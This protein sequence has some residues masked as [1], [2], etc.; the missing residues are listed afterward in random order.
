VRGLPGAPPEL[1][2]GRRR[3]TL[4][5]VQGCFRRTLPLDDVVTGQEFGRVE[6]LPPGWLVEG[7]LLKVRRRPGDGIITGRILFVQ[8]GS[9]SS[10]ARWR[11][12]AADRHPEAFRVHPT[13][14]C[15]V[16]VR[17]HLAASPQVAR[18]LTPS[19]TIGPAS[20][21]H[22]LMPVVAGCPEI[23]ASRPGEEPPVW[24]PPREDLRTWDASLATPEGGPLLPGA[25]D[26]ARHSAW[27][28]FREFCCFTSC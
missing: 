24:G 16:H 3:R 23:C 20:A 14:G 19:A 6:N 17:L 9:N 2:E 1:F 5:T 15:S 12:I 27:V 26:T 8:G 7:V 13:P 10:F 22:M 25:A 28:S 4:V 11:R 18:A 21:P